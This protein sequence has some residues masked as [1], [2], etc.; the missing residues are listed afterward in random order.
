MI[1]KEV[2]I[3]VAGIGLIGL[4]HIE[5][6]QKAKNV[7][8]VLLIEKDKERR[9]NLKKYNLQLYENIITATNHEKIDGM[10]I[11]TPNTEHLKNSID[12]INSGCNVLIEKPISTHSTDVK[13]LIKHKTLNNVEI[14]VGHHR[15]HNPIIKKA[16]EIID[17]GELGELKTVHINCLMHKPN[18]YFKSSKWRT[19]KGSGPILVNLIHDID[20]I[21]FLCGD[22]ISVQSQ[23]KPS[24]KGFENEEVAGAI[25]RFKNGMI[26]S[27]LVSDTVASPWSWELTARENEIYPS[28]PESCYQIG[29]SVGSM[30][31]PNL[32]I[33]KHQGQPDWYNPM[34]ATKVPYKFSDPLVNQINHF[35]E[36]IRNKTNPIISAETAMKT[37][38]VIEA[39]HNSSKT[40]QIVEL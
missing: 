12:A 26:G 39:I 27:V 28:T 13:K 32:T 16:K 3:A 29:G 40:N 33:W 23:L 7:K 18:Q 34:T 22:I 37:L 30:S 11:S 2:R 35:A 4:K 19:K 17:N 38:M 5:A 31:L 21:N 9:E 20:L 8:L 6:I 15:R 24:S 25:L 10:I 36:I 14:L 1:N